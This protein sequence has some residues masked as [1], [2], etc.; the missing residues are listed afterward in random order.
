MHLSMIRP[1]TTEAGFK[2]KLGCTRSMVL[3]PHRD[4]SVTR[5]ASISRACASATTF[6]RS[7]VGLGIISKP[8]G[9]GTQ[10]TFD[11]HREVNAQ[12]VAH[13]AELHRRMR[14]Y[15]G[16]DPMMTLTAEQPNAATVDQCEA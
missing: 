2:I 14:R 12:N 4:S 11:H 15:R 10:I 9:K 8:P 1:R 7:T 5:M 6:L 16:D 3:R 13:P